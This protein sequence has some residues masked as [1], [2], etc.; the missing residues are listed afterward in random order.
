[1]LV[2]IEYQSAIMT[3]YL[4]LQCLFNFIVNVAI[5]KVVKPTRKREELSIEYQTKP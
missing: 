3:T 2:L 1:M 5:E 4:V